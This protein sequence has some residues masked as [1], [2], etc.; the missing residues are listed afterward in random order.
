MPETH[1]ISTD[2]ALIRELV[3]S[4]CRHPGS[5][6]LTAK[7]FP[8]RA[9]WTLQ[10]HADDQPK[11][12]GKLG[13]HFKAFRQLIQMIGAHAQMAYHF[14]LLEPPP[15]S[16]ELM[17]PPKK[18]RTYD[19]GPAEK[20]LDGLVQAMGVS[21]Y[22]IEPEQTTDDA[23]LS[24]L[25]YDF[26]VYVRTADDHRMMTTAIGSIGTLFRS[27]AMRDGVSFV[28]SVHMA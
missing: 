18:A 6:I 12:I 28:V 15:G 26:K 1:E 27:R 20:L 17:H 7:Q 8:S 24:R 5:V 25:A 21:E 2:E 22:K 14:E 10:V 23:D 3:E 9:Y 16:C 13:T 4:V 11:L 19:T